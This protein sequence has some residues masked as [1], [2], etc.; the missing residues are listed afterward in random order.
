MR[1]PGTDARPAVQH[2]AALTAL[3]FPAALAILIHHCNGVFWPAAELGPL[4]AGVSFFFVLSGYILT[5][6]YGGRVI[7]PNALRRFHVAR[8]A[9]IWPFD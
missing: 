3:R 6:V 4:D 9:R 1:D 8:I 2:L 5:H 7:G